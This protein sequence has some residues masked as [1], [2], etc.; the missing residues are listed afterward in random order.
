[1]RRMPFLE[2]LSLNLHENL[3]CFGMCKLKSRCWQNLLRPLIQNLL[4]SV[5]LTRYLAR[6]PSVERTYPWITGIFRGFFCHFPGEYFVITISSVFWIGHDFQWLVFVSLN[7]TLTFILCPPHRFGLVWTASR[8]GTYEACRYQCVPRLYTFNNFT[9][10]HVHTSQ[11]TYDV[12]TLLFLKQI[13]VSFIYF[14]SYHTIL[15]IICHFM[16]FSLP[17]TYS[18]YGN[19][20]VESFSLPKCA[21][22]GV[23]DIQL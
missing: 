19:G 2:L 21:I 14:H 7:E 11:F 12:P 1:M 22:T 9:G 18:G 6:W 15:S 10:K 4:R 13:Y 8:H 23:C 5:T 3:E 17:R 20:E 16:I